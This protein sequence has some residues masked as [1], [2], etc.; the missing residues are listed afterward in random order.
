MQVYPLRMNLRLVALFN[1][2]FVGL[3]AHEVPVFQEFP[4]ESVHSQGAA[5]VVAKEEP[6]PDFLAVAY[7]VQV[8]QEE[9]LESAPCFFLG[10]L[11]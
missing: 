6:D 5:E 2:R 10:F 8:S 7:L 11:A 3:R 9:S 4:A 1:D